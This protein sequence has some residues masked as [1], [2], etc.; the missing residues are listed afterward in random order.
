[1]SI[2]RRHFIFRTLALHP[3]VLIST[4]HLSPSVVRRKDPWSMPHTPEH[5]ASTTSPANT[6]PPK[7]LPRHG[8]P[9]ETTRARL[10]YQSRKRGTLECDLLLSTFAQEHLGM[11]DAEELF[12]FDKVRV[13]S[14]LPFKNRLIL[15]LILYIY[16][17]LAYG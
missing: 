10:I 1:M 4:R 16:L 3:R 6:P 7:P 2:F 9:I 17:F 8:E 14:F 5:I 12:E 11:M 15:F 13:R